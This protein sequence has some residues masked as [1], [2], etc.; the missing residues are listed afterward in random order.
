MAYRAS[1]FVRRHRAGRRCCRRGRRRPGGALYAVNRERLIAQ[2]HF[3][4]VRQLAN[5]LFEIDVQVRRLPGSS[6]T[7]QLLVDTS[8]DYLRRLAADAGNDPDLA[9][10]VG[11]AYLRVARVEGVAVSSNLGQTEKA[12]GHL[13]DAQTFIDWCRR[14]AAGQSHRAASL[15]AGRARPHDCRRAARPARRG[16]PVRQIAGQR[17]ER[18]LATGADRSRRGRAGRHRLH[19][20]RQ[21][22]HDGRP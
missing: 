13:Q 4:E 18:Y 5:K 16:I 6:A 21:P 1:R 19:E 12:A 22:L 14:Q 9:L 10:D 7:R 3:D 8:L 20:R 17:L 11:T 2:R 15:G